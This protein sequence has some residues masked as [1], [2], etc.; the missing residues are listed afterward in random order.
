MRIVL[1]VEKLSEEANIQHRS[2]IRV[3]RTQSK[4]CA[5]YVSMSVDVIFIKWKYQVLNQT[6][7]HWNNK[8]TVAD[9]EAKQNILT[10]I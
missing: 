5:M 6:R 9:L 2:H 7:Q 3:S 10:S 4:F 8:Q 1:S